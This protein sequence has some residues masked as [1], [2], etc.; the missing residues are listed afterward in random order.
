[1][2]IVI[3]VS[4]YNSYVFEKELFES[5]GLR[6]KIHLIYKGEQAEKKEFSKSA[7]GIL[8]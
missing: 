2:E 1:M 6:M 8:V 4:G 7:V 3:L 5:C